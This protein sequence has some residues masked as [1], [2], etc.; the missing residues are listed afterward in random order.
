V[1]S[2][3]WRRGKEEEEEKR[4]EEDEEEDEGLSESEPNAR[5]GA[6]PR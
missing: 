1:S 2:C 3:G 4:R 5:Y 6:K